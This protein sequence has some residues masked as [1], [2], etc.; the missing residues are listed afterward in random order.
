MRNGKL[1]NRSIFC[2]FILSVIGCGNPT[3]VNKNHSNLSDYLDSLESSL[4]SMEDVI[5]IT[6]YCD[7]HKIG[8]HFNGVIYSLSCFENERILIDMTS[9]DTI[10]ANTE[11]ISKKILG[12]KEWLDEN[13]CLSISFNDAYVS[14]YSNYSDSTYSQIKERYSDHFD[15][16]SGLYVNKLRGDKFNSYSYKLNL[17]YIRKE[18]NAR[19]V[20][21]KLS[22]LHYL[23]KH[24]ERLYYYRSF[25][26][27]NVD[28]CSIECS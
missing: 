10:V 16:S 15:N 9:H 27:Y 23:I 2:Y 26:N 22:K 13:R 28:P 20:I 4:N 5:S 12:G 7:A 24:S 3:S 19:E 11:Y 14:V 1:L 18:E 21:K 17:I 6:P 8:A 25:Q